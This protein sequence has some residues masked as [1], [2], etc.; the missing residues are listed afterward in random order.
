MTDLD[1]RT[2]QLTFSGSAVTATDWWERGLFVAPYHSCQ[3]S[4]HVK[5]TSSGGHGPG[6][7]IRPF[8][9]IGKGLHQPVGHL[10]ASF[11]VIPMGTILK[12]RIIGNILEGTLHSP[13]N[14]IIMEHTGPAI[15][16]AVK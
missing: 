12:D 14:G 11:G 7:L 4:G 8:G 16:Y 9:D 13:K 10:A 15:Y 5:D 3:L 2:L 1:A 6:Q